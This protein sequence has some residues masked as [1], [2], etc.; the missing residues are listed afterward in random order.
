MRSMRG[1]RESR[2]DMG[3][4]VASTTVATCMLPPLPTTLRRCRM[5]QHIIMHSLGQQAHPAQCRKC[6]VD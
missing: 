1:R 6:V 5:V 2:L 3:A 4:E